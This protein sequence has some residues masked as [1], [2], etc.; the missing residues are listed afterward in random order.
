MCIRDSFFPVGV[1]TG[2]SNVCVRSSVGSAICWGAANGIVG[3][4]YTTVGD[5]S[6]DMGEQLYIITIPGQQIEDI[7]IAHSTACALLDD[8]SVICWGGNINGVRGG[9]TSSQAIDEPHLGDIIDLGTDRTAVVLDG[10]GN[11]MCAV[12]DNGD[13]KCWGENSNGLLGQGLS[14]IH[15]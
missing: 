3:P 13:V 7:A 15:I 4:R 10:D 1:T 6:D 12:L 5:E 11:T 8:G 14:L 9:G 2:K